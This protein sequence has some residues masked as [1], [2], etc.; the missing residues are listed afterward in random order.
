MSDYRE[1]RADHAQVREEIGETEALLIQM[2]TASK[3]P[4]N[5]HDPY[6]A[7][8]IDM[9]GAAPKIDGASRDPGSP[10]DPSS[11]AYVSSEVLQCTIG[12]DGNW[13]GFDDPRSK[14]FG[15]RPAPP[16]RP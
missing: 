16:W 13:R 3:D 9:P 15:G 12:L 7:E 1:L 5:P 11:K 8:S 10:D 4:G 6:S 14:A 2:E